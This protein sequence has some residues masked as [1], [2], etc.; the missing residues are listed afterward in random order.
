MFCFVVCL[1]FLY[2]HRPLSSADI[3][4]RVIGFPL[5]KVSAGAKTENFRAR[6]HSRHASF[7][8]ITMSSFSEVLFYFVC[9]FVGFFLFFFFLHY[10]YR[11]LTSAKIQ[12]RV[13]G[14]LLRKVSARTKTELFRA[15]THSRHASPTLAIPL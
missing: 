13:I 7:T 3:Q 10:S 5:L 8:L 11:P 4:S 2:S 1:F 12:S 9:W 14:F 15:S 6:T